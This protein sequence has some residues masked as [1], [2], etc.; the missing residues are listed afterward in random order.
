MPIQKTSADYF[1]EL[2]RRVQERKGITIK[3][4]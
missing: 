1:A 4:V 3:K 2:H